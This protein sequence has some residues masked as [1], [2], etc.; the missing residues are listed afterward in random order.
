MKKTFTFL[1]ILFCFG[2]TGLSITGMSDTVRLISYFDGLIQAHLD[3]KNIAGATVSFVK[4]GEILFSKGYGYADLENKTLVD[5][6]K[7]LFRI[8][9]VSK[10][11][12]WTAVM[13]LYEKGQLDL[14]EDI[15]TYLTNIEIPENYEQPLTLKHIMTH[16]AGFEDYILGLFARDS[17][18]LKPLEVILKEQMPARVRP[19]GKFS[20]YSNHATAIAAY[21]VEQVSGKTFHEYV[22]Q[23][24]LGPLHMKRTTFRQPVPEQIEATLSKG[25]QYA[26]GELKER[27]FEYVPLY[28]AGSASSTAT[29]MARFMMAHLQLGSYQGV[30]ILDSATAEMMQSVA[31]RHHKSVNPM[32][33]GFM[34]MSQN[35][36][37]IIGHGGDTF[38]F[39]T[40]FA[41]MP[42]KQIGLFLS[43]NSDKGGEVRSDVLE[44][45]MD[46][47]FPEKLE[48]PEF[49]MPKEELMRFEGTYRANRYPHKRFTKIASLMGHTNVSATEDGRLKVK[50]SEVSYY[51]PLDTLV[52][53]NEK[54]SNTLVFKANEVG[55]ITHAFLDLAPIVAF[56]KIKPAE[57]TGFHQTLFALEL[58][59]FLMTFIYW[60]LVYFIRKEYKQPLYRHLSFKVKLSGWVA[61]FFFLIFLLLLTALTSDGNEIVFG[62]TPMMKIVFVF[63]LLG[64]AA[65]LFV[66][67]YTYKVWKTS[68]YNWSG[69]I[70]YSV[71]LLAI[72][73]LIWQLNYWN[74]L[75]FQY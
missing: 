27:Y 44:E 13:Q 14:E 30:S 47:Y 16:S 31:F 5:P 75:G 39:H 61:T 8:G 67:Y 41:F 71:L 59:V 55:T 20:S 12:L 49:S 34:D 24:I 63:P 56:E 62:V 51:I 9:S 23:H 68:E 21:I 2:Q 1:L 65:A 10:L 6:S 33:Y 50:N 4:K 28:P 58:I 54:N 35:G 36:I 43:F 53:R 15:N 48:D 45:W 72:A 66:A 26:G 57:S 19:P 18:A 32:R 73:A 17:S 60:P 22:E 37:E 70:H 46:Y 7:T 64:I 38:W 42:D 29:D 25:Y 11:F 74:L 40:L 69:K 3:D 52:F